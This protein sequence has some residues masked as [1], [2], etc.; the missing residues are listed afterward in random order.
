MLPR[1]LNQTRAN[2][3]GT[4]LLAGLQYSWTIEWEA[5]SM[6]YTS[7]II[8][9]PLGTLVAQR[10]AEPAAFNSDLSGSARISNSTRDRF[11]N[12]AANKSG[13][14]KPTWSESDKSS[15]PFSRQTGVTSM[16]TSRGAMTPAD[17]ELARI[18]A[19]IEGGKVRVDHEIKRLEEVHSPVHVMMPAPDLN[20][21]T[22]SS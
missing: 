3:L 8:G 10:I 15:S 22:F 9:L 21:V 14:L 17:I 19:D 13:L 16:V 4:V 20:R 6:V 11:Q 5:G 1:S 12:Y 7:V 2:A 18:D